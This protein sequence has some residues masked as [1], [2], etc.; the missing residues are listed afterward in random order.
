VEIH[1]DGCSLPY[2][3]FDQ[4]PH[5]TEDAIAENKRL[6]VTLTVIQAVQNERNRTRL[7]SK[8]FTIRQK[9]RIPASGRCEPTVNAHGQRER[10]TGCGRGLLPAA[11]E[12]A[13]RT[14]EGPEP[15]G[16]STPPR[17]HS[18][19][20]KAD[21][22]T[23]RRSQALGATTRPRTSE[24]AKRGLDNEKMAFVNAYPP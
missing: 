12:E 11:R 9:D 1:A 10:P 13:R 20:A 21:I 15:E 19:P 2:S 14:K 24:G 8:A 23:W 3:I 4:N 7:D 22:S 5:V 17:V 6:G 16:S 18:Y